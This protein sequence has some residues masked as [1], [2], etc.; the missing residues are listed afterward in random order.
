MMAKAMKSRKNLKNLPGKSKPPSTG[1]WSQES[2]AR[3]QEFMGHAIGRHADAYLKNLAM[4]VVQLKAMTEIAAI[5]SDLLKERAEIAL[6]TEAIAESKVEIE[7]VKRQLILE[8][9]KIAEV[10]DSLLQAEEAVETKKK[11]ASAAALIIKAAV[12]KAVVKKTP[13]GSG[14]RRG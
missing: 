3:L 5:Q 1:T 2:E 14:R 11:P 10:R 9:K 13:F 6:Q 7:Q 12:K 4:T 8:R